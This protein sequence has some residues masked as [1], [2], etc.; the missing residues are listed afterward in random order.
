MMNMMLLVPALR[1][2]SLFL[3]DKKQGYMSCMSE[4][5]HPQWN[6]SRIEE[7]THH[8][9]KQLKINFKVIARTSSLYLEFTIRQLSMKE[10][11]TNECS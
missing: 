6:C 8:T 11:C 7:N 1:M 10:K 3:Y 4:E 5:C 9:Q 2:S